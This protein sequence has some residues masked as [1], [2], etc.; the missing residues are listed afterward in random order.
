MREESIIAHLMRRAEDCRARSTAA[1]SEKHCA[2]WQEL[3]EQCDLR[4]RLLKKKPA[5][6]EKAE[7]PN[8]PAP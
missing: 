2:I 8:H 3:A 1:T 7:R 4:V 6:R 5:A